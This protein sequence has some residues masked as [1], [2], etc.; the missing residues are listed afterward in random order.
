MA[1]VGIQR[2]MEGLYASTVDNESPEIKK[3]S[4]IAQSIDV[5]SVTNVCYRKN[6]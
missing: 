4:F 2:P 1:S 5:D 6:S 3:A